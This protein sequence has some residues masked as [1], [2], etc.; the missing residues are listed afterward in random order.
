[1]NLTTVSGAVLILVS[2]FLAVLTSTPAAQT[3]AREPSFIRAS[4]TAPDT[5]VQLSALI[6]DVRKGADAFVFLSGGASKMR[7][8]HQR[9]LLAIFDALSLL[10]KA[11]HRL[12]VGDGGTKAGIMEAAGLA[13]KASGHAFPLIGLAPA[14][15]IPPRG[16]TPVDPNHSHI[17]AVDNPAAPAGDAWGSE[18]GTMYWFFA[19]LAEGRPS[20][21]IVAN[22]GGITLAEVEANVRAGR[23]MILIEGSGRA[24]DALVSLL[25][26]TTPAEAEVRALRDRAEKATLM[27]RPELFQVLALQTGAP[28][29]RDAIVAAIG[30]TK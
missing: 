6:T 25:K 24:A 21:T 19:K 27:R 13:R 29:L 10:T 8:D 1:M 22:G 18:T 20:V 12:A 14:A 26:K 2:A 9:Q 16:L 17:V 3:A 30:G 15:E 5:N 11:G 28:G 23:R 4:S 7:E